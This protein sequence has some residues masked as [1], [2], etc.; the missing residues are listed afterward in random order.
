M[1]GALVSPFLFRPVALVTPDGKPPDPKSLAVN[2]AERFKGCAPIEIAE[3]DLESAR[4]AV[5]QLGWKAAGEKVSHAAAVLADVPKKCGPTPFS[6][7]EEAWEQLLD[8]VAVSSHV[9]KAA[10]LVAGLEVQAL[11]DRNELPAGD[12]FH[13]TVR[14]RCR[15]RR[16]AGWWIRNLCRQRDWWSASAK[17]TWEKASPIRFECRKRLHHRSISSPVTRVQILKAEICRKR[18]LVR[19]VGAVPAGRPRVPLS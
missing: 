13:V 7:K 10:A 14:A 11:A 1:T 15:A 19:S 6:Q 3:R 12:E 5:L 17:V 9:D 2:I 16:V 4:D 8:R 18:L